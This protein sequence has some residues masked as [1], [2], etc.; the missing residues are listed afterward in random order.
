MTW[1]GPLPLWQYSVATR[2]LNSSSLLFFQSNNTPTQSLILP[3]PPPKLQPVADLKIPN[4]RSPSLRRQPSQL[5]KPASLLLPVHEQ[6][7]QKG[8]RVWRNTVG[9]KVGLKVMSNLDVAAAVGKGDRAAQ[10]HILAYC[11]SCWGEGCCSWHVHAVV[12]GHPYINLLIFFVYIDQCTV[13]V[14]FQRLEDTC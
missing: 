12:S 9:N 6:Q 8:C 11:Q 14:Y 7:S 1:K 5:I 4:S 10:G 3:L 2:I 13:P